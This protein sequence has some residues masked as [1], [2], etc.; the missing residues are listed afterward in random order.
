M[1]QRSLPSVTLGRSIRL[2]DLTSR[3]ALS[4]G[5][6]ASVGAN[7]RYDESQAFAVRAVELGFGGVRYLV[8]HDLRQRL[9][10]VALFAPPGDPGAQSPDWPYAADGPIPAKLVAEAGRAFGYRVLPTT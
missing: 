9:Y 3:R 1:Q 2:A 7:E 6:T 4:F 10:G 5:V 8:R